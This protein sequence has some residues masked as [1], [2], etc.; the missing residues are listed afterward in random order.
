MAEGSKSANTLP[1]I[2]DLPV[3]VAVCV[4]DTDVTTR[5]KYMETQMR[6]C[7]TGVLPKQQTKRL[8]EELLPTWCV[9]EFGSLRPKGFTR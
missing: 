8:V 6:W 2:A 5:V 3:S 1:K 7:G 9:M 4:G